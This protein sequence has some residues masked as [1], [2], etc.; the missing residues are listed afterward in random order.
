MYWTLFYNLLANLSVVAFG[1]A[2]I[3]GMSWLRNRSISVSKDEKLS[4]SRDI[5][6]ELKK[7]NLAVGVYYGL[8]ILGAFVFVGLC[9]SRVSL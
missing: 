9:L 4:F 5:W 6:P 3:W 2:V 1:F 8:Y 7:G